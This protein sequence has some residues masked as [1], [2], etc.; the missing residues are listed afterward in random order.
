MRGAAPGGAWHCAAGTRCSLLPARYWTPEKNALFLWRVKKNIK[1]SILPPG[2]LVPRRQKK[3]QG[4]IFHISF[5]L[6]EFGTFLGAV[7]N[8]ELPLPS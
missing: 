3:Y 7:L 5:D 4:W 2:W 6:L 1:H 8:F